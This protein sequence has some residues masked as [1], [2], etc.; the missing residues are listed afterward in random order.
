MCVLQVTVLPE[1]RGGIR[2]TIGEI[3]GS[4][5]PLG[6]LRM[7]GR[8]QLK[9]K[10]RM[11]P[12]DHRAQTMTRLAERLERHVAEEELNA[13][14]AADA[15]NESLDR[16]THF[17]LY[18]LAR[19]L[20]TVQGHLNDSPPRQY[21]WHDWEYYMRLI[22][23]RD[24]GDEFPGQEHPNVLVPKALKL[25][26]EP[27]SPGAFDPALQPNTEAAKATSNGR[28]ASSGSDETATGG[29]LDGVVDR[30]TLK[31]QRGLRRRPTEDPLGDWSWLSDKSPLLSTEPEAK[32][33]VDRLSVALE[34][35]LNRQRKGHK[36]TPPIA[37]AHI[38]RWKTWSGNEAEHKL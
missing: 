28:A 33:L 4:F 14:L 10:P 26:A 3:T 18:V 1:K 16:D 12:A 15:E 37:L 5:L 20:R 29:K 35:E 32:W 8:H 2:A 6:I 27:F 36:R 7:F 11:S 19:E 30:D 34:R 38:R 9:H 31:K 17:Y 23:N 25:P 22:G 13:A 21:S 24:D